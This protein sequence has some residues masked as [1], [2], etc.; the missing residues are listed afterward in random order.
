MYI[1]RYLNEKINKLNDIKYIIL[2]SILARSIP[3]IFLPLIN[4]YEKHIGKVGRSDILN[5]NNK[6]LLLLLVVV[7]GPIFESYMITFII[8]ILQ[9][10]FKFKNKLNILLI[11]AIIF[12]SIHY[13][14]ML[15]M[16]LIFIP[17][18]IFV[19]SYMYY[20]PKYF[21]SF[22]IMT[23]VHATFNLMALLTP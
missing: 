22:F 12:S 16:I 7:I 6:I 19:Y 10:K 20:K 13:Y 18:L 9:T 11:T 5:I 17:G 23:S 21:S 15:Y 1:C 2:M 3:Y 4:L 8:K 14:S